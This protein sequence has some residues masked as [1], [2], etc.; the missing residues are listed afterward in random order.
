MLK[1]N[2]GLWETWVLWKYKES[3]P[4]FTDSERGRINR[5]LKSIRAINATPAGLQ[6]RITEYCRRWPDV[7]C[8]LTA[9]AAH[10][11]SLGILP[12]KN[13][14][15]MDDVEL[16]RLARERGINTLGKSKREILEKLQ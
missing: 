8:T 4:L 7:E 10:W 9:I 13:P 15:D 14:R 3:T 11:N 2:Q 5:A 16:L 1:D 12:P 6:A